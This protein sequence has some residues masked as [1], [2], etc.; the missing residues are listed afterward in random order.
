MGS[1]G[2]QKSV[3]RDTRE[4]ESER[5]RSVRWGNA[6]NTLRVSGRLLRSMAAALRTRR[7][8][9]S[10]LKPAG[11]QRRPKIITGAGGSWILVCFVLFCFFFSPV[12]FLVKELGYQ[13]PRSCNYHIYT[14]HNTSCVTH[15]GI[16][17]MNGTLTIACHLIGW[18]HVTCVDFKFLCANWD[19]LNSPI[20]LDPKP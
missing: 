19:Y 6:T 15:N 7:R 13:W 11:S 5:E 3:A 9:R 12:K 16:H 1:D 20:V 8:P 17:G 10:F 18:A 4:K 14:L 2:R